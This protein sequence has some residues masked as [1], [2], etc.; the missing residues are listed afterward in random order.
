VEYRAYVIVRSGTRRYRSLLVE[1]RANMNVRSGTDGCI[2]T[3]VHANMH[4]HE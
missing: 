2:Q 1:Y 4:V 3:A